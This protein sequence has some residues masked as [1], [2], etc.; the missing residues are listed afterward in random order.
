M[1]QRPVMGIVIDAGHGGEDPGAVGNGITE[2]NMTLM[3]S[4]IMYDKFKEL[5]YPVTMT[6]TTDETLSPS[7]RVRRILTAYGDNPNVI[8]ISNHINAGGGEGH[9]VTIKVQYRIGK[10]KFI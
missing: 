3:I 8:V 6:R 9:C 4:K 1:N 5:G 10:Y 2:K 7:E